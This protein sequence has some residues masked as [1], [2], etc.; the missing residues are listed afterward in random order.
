MEE[1][2]EEEEEKFVIGMANFELDFL[3][4]SFSKED[5]F[6]AVVEVGEEAEEEEE[7]E[8]TGLEVTTILILEEVTIT[9]E[10]ILNND[11]M[12]FWP[13]KGFGLQVKWFVAQ[14]KGFVAQMKWFVAQM[15]WFG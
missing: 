3:V 6:F 14:M 10:E 12:T 4:W 9:D 2:E 1:E 7:K 5:L 8:V 11:D 13:Q 15:K